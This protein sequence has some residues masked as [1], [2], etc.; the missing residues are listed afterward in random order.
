MDCAVL[1]SPI[2]SG[3]APEAAGWM[4]QLADQLATKQGTRLLPL[5]PAQAAGRQPLQPLPLLC[6]WDSAQLHRLSLPGLSQSLPTDLL[7][8]LLITH[9]VPQDAVALGDPVA[10]VPLQRQKLVVPQLAA[11]AEVGHCRAER[12]PRR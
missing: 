11:V 3:G 12:R 5:L 1:P 2:C 4:M 9:L 7:L 6:P 8:H 10:Y